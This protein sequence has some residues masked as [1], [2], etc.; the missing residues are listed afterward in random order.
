MTENKENKEI[1]FRNRVVDKGQLKK[2][3]SWSFMN[4]GTARTA[5]MA[6]KLK[7]LGF[8]FATRAGVSI[9]VDDLQVPPIKRQLLE[10]A[11]EEIR[12]T[13]QKYT[14]GEITEVERFQKV[15]DTWNSTS[16]DLKDEVVKN[17]RA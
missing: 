15:I 12:I 7:D 3:I 13:E 16:E 8:R 14:R 10:A 11:E 5:Q 17:F 2:L 1:V 4:Y 6:D 9:S